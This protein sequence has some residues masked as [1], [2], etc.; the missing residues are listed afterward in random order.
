MDASEAEERLLRDK[1]SNYNK[2]IRPVNNL[3]HPV[4]VQF[5]MSMVQLIR[6]ALGTINA[7]LLILFVCDRIFTV[8]DYNS[9]WMGSLTKTPFSSCQH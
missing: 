9:R 5:G 7:Q 2:L 1:M 3:T 8:A 4:H 6:S